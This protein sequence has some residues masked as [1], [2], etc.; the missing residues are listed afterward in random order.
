MLTYY[1]SSETIGRPTAKYSLW[2]VRL[3]FLFL[4][5]FSFSPGASAQADASSEAL[6]A[7]LAQRTERI[8]Q[9]LDTR[10]VDLQ[11]F[12][13]GYRP[14]AVITTESLENTTRRITFPTYLSISEDRKTRII[15]RLA[16][17]YPYMSGMDIHTE[18][19]FVTFLVAAGTSD[20]EI[21]AILDHFGYLGHE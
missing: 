17:H 11:L 16:S 21:D 20:E 7:L 13:L 18:L 8:G 4:F 5:S 6:T 19:Q 12:N 15:D 9:S 1:Y 10:E 14:K 3:F 2:S